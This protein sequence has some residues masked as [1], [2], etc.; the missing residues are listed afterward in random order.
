MALIKKAKI[1]KNRATFICPRCKQSKTSDVSRFKDKAIVIKVKCTCPC[2]HT[3]EVLLERRR[4]ERK[5]VAI[6]GT[7]YQQLAS[8]DVTNHPMVIRDISISGLRIQLNTAVTTITPNKK[9]FVKFELNDK[10][11]SLVKRHVIV[12]Y[13]NITEQII[14]VEFCSIDIPDVIGNFLKYF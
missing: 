1:I 3:F 6:A 12:R 5:S 11:N 14:G 4:H 10:Q 13:V 9:L 7:L 2:G 8:E